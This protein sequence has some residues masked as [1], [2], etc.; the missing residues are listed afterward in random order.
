MREGG[1]EGMGMCRAVEVN[2]IGFNPV[3]DYVW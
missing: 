1:W 3:A 2:S